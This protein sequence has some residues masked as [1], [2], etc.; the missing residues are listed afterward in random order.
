ME[1]QLRAEL[2]M[3]CGSCATYAL[4]NRCRVWSRKRKPVTITHRHHQPGD[5][6]SG[7]VALVGSPTAGADG[8]D[9]DGENAFTV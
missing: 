7:S 5:G 6:Q 1:S 9:A 3:G 2:G 8:G 4:A